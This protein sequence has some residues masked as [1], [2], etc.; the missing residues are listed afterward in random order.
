MSDD[1][2][3][4]SNYE[5]DLPPEISRAATF[6][7][8]LALNVR[9]GREANEKHVSGCEGGACAIPADRGQT[10]ELPNDVVGHAVMMIKAPTRTQAAD[11]DRQALQAAD[12][13]R[14]ALQA[15]DDDRQPFDEGSGL[16]A[17]RV[18]RKAVDNG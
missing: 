4:Y 6:V 18:I 12:D 15:A 16:Q 1:R 13:D 9:D 14:Q 17:D 8:P 11:D 7:I 2:S 5:S 3:E 10:S